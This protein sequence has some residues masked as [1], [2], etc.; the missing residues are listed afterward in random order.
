MRN[1]KRNNNKKNHFDIVYSSVGV[2]VDEVK[3][4]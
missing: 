2:I 4:I 3:Y 1:K